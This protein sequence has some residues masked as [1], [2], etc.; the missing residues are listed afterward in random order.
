M[1]SFPDQLP[2]NSNV[3]VTLSISIPFVL[4]YIKSI[5]QRSTCFW[6]TRWTFLWIF[7]F[8]TASNSHCRFTSNLLCRYQNSKSGICSKVKSRL[9][10]KSC[11]IFYRVPTY[12][13][14][15]VMVVALT[16][17]SCIHLHRQYNSNGAYTLDI[18]GPLM[19][20]TQKVTS[21]AFSIHDGFVA[22][23][24]KKVCLLDVTGSYKTYVKFQYFFDGYF[25]NI[26]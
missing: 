14:R 8:W 11:F 6:I 5:S 20:I 3:S 21:L 26:F 23:E 24:N 17:L 10:I 9:T 12:F 15:I 19:I 18:T 13:D 7:L 1:L 2:D 4:A 22:T 16:Y 25:S